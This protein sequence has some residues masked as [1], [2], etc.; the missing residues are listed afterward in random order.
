[1]PAYWLKLIGQK[2][3]YLSTTE[4]EEAH[5]LAA[6]CDAQGK[7]HSIVWVKHTQGV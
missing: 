5:V 7:V 1:M 6:A 2:Y 4:H 3:A